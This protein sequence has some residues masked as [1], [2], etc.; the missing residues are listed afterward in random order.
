MNKTRIIPIVLTIT[1]MILFL[2]A[3]G[4]IGAKPIAASPSGARSITGILNIDYENA[5]P[6]VHQLAVGTFMLE[7]SEVPLTSDQAAQLATLW[8][9]YRALIN[10]PSSATIELEGLRRQIER[11]YSED[12]L[13]AIAAMRL[14]MRDMLDLS[15]ARSI[16]L[17]GSGA[18]GS[19]EMTAEMQATRQALR[20]AAQSSGGGGSQGGG[21]GMFFQGGGPPPDMGGGGT[22]GMGGGL[23]PEMATT[24]GTVETL[25]ARGADLDRINPGLVEALIRY[26]QSM[27]GG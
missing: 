16:N 18:G 6:L 2:A 21:G 7:E 14:T 20:A 24:P 10:S 22:G 26:L 12:Q 27:A 1:V 17:Q 19:S 25:S 13:K 15:A 9:G 5:L 23:G 3:C 4:S 8:K 11:A